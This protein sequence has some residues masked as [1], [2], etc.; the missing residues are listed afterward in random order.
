MTPEQEKENLVGIT[1]GGDGKYYVVVTAI[2]QGGVGPLDTIEEAEKIRQEIIDGMV[3][4]DDEPIEHNT[5]VEPMTP[6]TFKLVVPD[7]PVKPDGSGGDIF[8]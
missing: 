8:V 1:F 7:Q 4:Q 2:P 3:K 5:D 6:D